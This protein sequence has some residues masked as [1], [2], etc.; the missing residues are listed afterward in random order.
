MSRVILHRH[1]AKYLKRL[2]KD[3]KQRIKSLLTQLEQ[4]PLDH[5]NV[6]KMAGEW[7]GYQRLRSGNLRIIFWFDVEEDIVY[8]DHIGTRG[9]IYK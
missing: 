2:P 9:D 6:K 8:V 5:P 3:Q 7:A 1:A 4:S